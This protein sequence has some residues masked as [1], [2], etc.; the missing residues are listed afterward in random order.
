MHKKKEKMALAQPL[1]TGLIKKW[2]SK[3]SSGFKTSRRRHLPLSGESFQACC[4]AGRS[5]IWSINKKPFIK[6]DIMR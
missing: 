2:F 5:I 1:K 3:K 4:R 6:M